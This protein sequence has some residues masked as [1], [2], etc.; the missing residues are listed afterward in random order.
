MTP[1]TPAI[2]AGVFL[3]CLVGLIGIRTIVHALA[4][5]LAD[6]RGPDR[7]LLLFAGGAFSIAIIVMGTFSGT[8]M[9]VDYLRGVF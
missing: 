5:E 3:A 7:S 2:F 8:A 9:A 4:R 1:S 6:T